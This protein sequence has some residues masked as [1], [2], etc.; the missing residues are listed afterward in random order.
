VERIGPPSAAVPV[1][2]T[3]SPT[4]MRMFSANAQLDAVQPPYN[5]CERAIEA[6]VLPYAVGAGLTVS[7]Y[8]AL[9]RGLLSGRMTAN[10]KF[11]GDDLRKV[12]PKFQGKRR[13]Y[14]T[15]VASRS[16]RTNGSVNRSCRLRCVGYSTKDQ[17]SPC[18]VLAILVS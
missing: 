5:L 17:R 7:S 13:Q 11:D 12:D 2:G 16:W 1:C 8:G 10:T 3:F 14:L 15:A 6:D 4:Q 18:G 9:C